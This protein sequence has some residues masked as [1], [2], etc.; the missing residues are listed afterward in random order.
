MELLPREKDKLLLFT[1]ALLAER[2]LARGLK[3]NYPEAVALISMEIM[4]GAR[5]GRSVAELMSYGKE[6]LSI[7]Q[8]MDGVASMIPEVQVEATFPDGTK[9]VTVHDPI[10]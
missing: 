1:A 2:R 8:V 10:N 9:L 5:D 3:L 4:E 7:D 6:I